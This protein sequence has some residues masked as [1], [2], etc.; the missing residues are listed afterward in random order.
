MS[1]NGD[2]EEL[3]ARFVDLTGASASH[4]QQY[5]AA[6]R[7]DLSGAAAEYFTALEEGTAGA[8]DDEENEAPEEPYTGPRTL[9]GRPAPQSI[10]TVASTSAAPKRKGGIATLGSISQSSSGAHAG[11][12]HDDDDS[13]DEDFDPEDEP[14][15]LF[16]GGEKS[17]LAVQDPSSSRNDPRKVVKDILKKAAQ[18][19]GKAPG[20][21][22]GESSSSAPN[23]FR[24]SGQTLG[25]DDTPS[26]VVPGPR[27]G[28]AEAEAAPVQRR[29]LHLWVDGFS[30]E[31]G[32]LR[33][34]DD[35]VHAQDL[36]MIR[37]G[38][39]PLHLMGVRE[40]QPVDV[41]LI[42]HN[43]AYEAPPKVYKPFSGSGNRLGSPTPG[44]SSSSTAPLAA[45][46]A[47][48][49]NSGSQNNPLEPAIDPSQPTLALRIQLANGA[50]LPARF[51]TT[52]TI[53][54][55][56]S[57]IDRAASDTGGRQWV[58]AT[59]FPSKEHTDKALVLGEMAEFKRGGTAVQKWA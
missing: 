28:T 18:N 36:Q 3:V 47:L 37:Q 2:H 23:R 10:P 54:D 13:D 19:A 15:D 43:G 39:A 42:K 6:N 14:R 5:L 38:R 11:H 56:Y 59:T 49:T 8:E 50:R 46:P 41:Q 22:G 44:A 57:F 30:V 52:S 40:D 21:R 51:N 17:G 1:D 20:E 24:G 58:L 29:I 26:Q 34:F 33:R 32:P 4:A 9:D 27:A 7:W 53:G 35:P 55:V 48:T 12:G 16:A 31:D 25:G 45:S